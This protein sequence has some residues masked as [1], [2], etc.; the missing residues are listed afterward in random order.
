MSTFHVVVNNIGKRNAFNF[1]KR[2]KNNKGPIFIVLADRPS[3]IK[4]ENAIFSQLYGIYSN[5]ECFDLFDDYSLCPS[6]AKKLNI[7]SGEYIE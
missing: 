7:F 1:V 2:L 6:S 5:E 4:E 3:Y